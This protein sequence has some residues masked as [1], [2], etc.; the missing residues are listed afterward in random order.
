MKE[1]F[2]KAASFSLDRTLL[3][4]ERTLLAYIRTAFSSFLLAIILFKFLEDGLINYLA[5]VFFVLS[6]IFISV[7]ILYYLMRKKQLDRAYGYM[8]IK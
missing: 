1:A 6:A 2:N 3:A 4:N 8:K 7:G 5:I